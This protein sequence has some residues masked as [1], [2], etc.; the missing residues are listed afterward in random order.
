MYISLLSIG[1]GAVLGAWIRWGI[2][3]QFNHYFPNIPL[4][5]VLVNLVGAFVIGF[6]VT[7]FASSSL[8]PNYKLFP[9]T[10]FCGALT[11]F[12]TF[13]M[14]VVSLLQ[15]GKFEYA[16]LT[17]T[18]HVLGSLLFTLLGIFTYQLTTTH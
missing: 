10:G 16:I 18:V 5:T 11:T 3:L 13:S 12:S 4:G 2:G 6:A 1:L 14:E 15:S 9:I 8:N 17:I 7:F